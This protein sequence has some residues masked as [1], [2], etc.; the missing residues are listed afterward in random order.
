M[1]D[2]KDLPYGPWKDIFSGIWSGYPVKIL[3]NQ[4]KQILTL[5]FDKKENKI[6]GIVIIMSNF[7]YSEEHLENLQFSYPDDS[8]ILEK[9][10]HGNITKFFGISTDPVYIKFEMSRIVNK[11]SELHDE[12]EFKKQKIYEL[13]GSLNIKIFDLKNKKE[14]AAKLFTEPIVF[15]AMISHIKGEDL[16]IEKPMKETVFLGFKITGEKAEESVGL[17]KSIVCVGE[18]LDIQRFHHILMEE[19][20][21]CG[22]N[23]VVWE[24]EGK[25]LN[26]GSASDK[27]DENSGLDPMGLPYKILEPQEDVFIDLNVLDGDM[28][29]ETLNLPKTPKNDKYTT[30]LLRECIE[31]ISK[32]N[33]LKDLIESLE[34]N[35]KDDKL[36]Y[37]KNRAIRILKLMDKK[38]P[39]LFS[40]NSLIM[41]NLEKKLVH[42]GKV[43][44]IKL[45]DKEYPLYIKRALFY[46]L[47]K[48][49]YDFYK[50]RGNPEVQTFFIVD[51]GKEFYEVN[52]EFKVVKENLEL[53][54]SYKYGLGYSLGTESELDL[55]PKVYEFCEL[56]VV[57]VT[58]SDYAIRFKVKKPYRIHLRHAMSK[59]PGSF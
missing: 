24:E 15:A 11:V 26:I 1:S 42:I 58:D 32:I 8:I 22:L 55:D 17:F 6:E 21:L 44:L 20:V 28:F 4:D 19:L 27:V 13:S 36:Q 29:L 3:E 18:K 59:G 41:D 43:L 53:L 50:E 2:F 45:D 23:V 49:M 51:N 33:N 10:Y 35:V 9:K 30:L 40:G 39:K 38:Y 14:L 52:S 56:K 7:Y 46:S 25:Y 31:N 47:F 34:N 16:N 54:D 5:I 57:H 48:N 37:F 12:L